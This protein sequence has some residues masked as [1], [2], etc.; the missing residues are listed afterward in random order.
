M[1]TKFTETEFP[2]RQQP[3]LREQNFSQ[4]NRQVHGDRIPHE[5]TTKYIWNTT[6][7]M[8]ITKSMELQNY[9]GDQINRTT[10]HTMLIKSMEW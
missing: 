2:V 8:I 5:I 4:E 10:L 3:S 6:L 7:H 1:T 9:D